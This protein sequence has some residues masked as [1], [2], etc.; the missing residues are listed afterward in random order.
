MP[1]TKS[2]LTITAQLFAAAGIRRV[3]FVDD[4][5]GISAERIQ[6]DADEL[7]MEQLSVCGAFPT[8]DFSSDDD[9][10]RRAL[11]VKA[12]SLGT[13]L[14]LEVM[15]DK[16]A[17]VRYDYA[18]AERDQTARRYFDAIIGSAVET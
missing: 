10:I 16:L 11:V 18:D 6:Y 12:I 9:D 15:F 13:A 1:E 2:E 8:V 17:A 7:S 14:E 5:F 4:R 3:V